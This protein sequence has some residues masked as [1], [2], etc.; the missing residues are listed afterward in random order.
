MDALR[1]GRVFLFVLSIVLAAAEDAQYSIPEVTIEAFTPKGFRASI[2]GSPNQS[3]F[4]FQGNLNRNIESDQV[5]AISGETLSVSSNG[6][7]IVDLPDI[8]L[9]AGDVIKY[10]VFAAI[11]R[12]GYVKDD[13][14]FTIEELKPYEPLPAGSAPVP[15]PLTPPASTSTTP[16]PECLPTLTRLRTGSACAGQTVFEE[17]FDSLRESMWQIEHYIPLDHPELP[18]VSYQKSAVSVKDGILR[19]RAALQQTQQGFTNESIYDGSL[20]LI[21][22]CTS[23][24]PHACE[25]HAEGANILPPVVSG[26]IVSRPGFAFTYGTV[27]VRAKLPKGDWLYPEILLEPFLKKFGS[28]P[29]NF[30]SGVLKIACARGNKDLLEQFVGNNQGNKFLYAGPIVAYKCREYLI[31]NKEG[32]SDWSNDFHIYSVKWTPDRFTFLV[33]GVQW[34]FIEPSPSGLCGKLPASCGAGSLPGMAPFDD[35]FYLTLGVAAGGVTDFKDLLTTTDGSTK[36]WR[37]QQSKAALNFWRHQ[38]AW[39][40]TWEQPELLVDYVKVEAL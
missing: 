27:S 26:R 1:C 5:G 8:Q 4:A 20:N 38:D 35:H 7:W 14:E 24:I 18:F 30:K 22:G 21:Q 2:P 40:P 6:R 39:H 36:P 16:A 15:V 11:D 13:L 32:Y 10:H 17:N 3:L 31:R 34:F 25:M 19:I 9:K 12:V 28:G 29:M 37:N 33:D 23:T